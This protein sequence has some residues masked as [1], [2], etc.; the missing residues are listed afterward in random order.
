M[1]LRELLLEF[2]GENDRVLKLEDFI[3]STASNVT[4]LDTTSNTI[5]LAVTD[6]KEIKE[7][8]EEITELLNN[9]EFQS[10]YEIVE[11]SKNI[12]VSI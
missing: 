2:A 6:K 12:V 8:I 4:V 1:N 7:H 5:R 3:S 9:S 11:E 10:D